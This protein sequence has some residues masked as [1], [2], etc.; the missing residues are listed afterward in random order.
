VY[1]LDPLA[2]S[3]WPDF[4]RRHPDASVFHTR[5]WLEALRRTYGYAAVAYTTSPPATPLTN[6]V[7]FCDVRSWLTGRRL[8]SLP[9][10]DHCEPLLGTAA[11][12]DAILGELRRSV[13]S[14]R[15]RYLE[16]RPTRMDFQATA[17]SSSSSFAF[18]RLD[19]QPSLD[20]LF[21]ALHKD[22]IQ[23]KVRRAEREALV[24]ETGRSASLVQA[25]YDL[26]LITRRRHQLPPQ[27]L[28]WFRTLT[29]CLGGRISI[30]IAAKEGV[31]VAG[32]VVLRHGTTLVYK[33][34]ASDARHHNLGA[35]PFLFWHA[36]REGKTAGFRLL[37]LGRS[38]SDNEGLI[39]FK[40]RL[41][42]ARTR[43]S[44]ARYPASTAPALG[45]SRAMAAARLIF[46]RL[47]DP[48]LATT[49]RLFY[50]HVG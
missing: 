5:E 31:P 38:D 37:D 39:T 43:L 35:M 15:W 46:A 14:R 13:D 30:S 50:R 23:R 22:S 26:Q 3:R 9:F 1:E 17:F 48:L 11:D 25:F 20:E 34:G 6:G 28:A 41:G 44:Y 19:L 21:R 2:D 4:V 42:A 7:V 32:I 27:P 40:D 47:P 12:R 29:D 33:Y 16:I 36:I 49:G 24:Y 10:A 18:H 8:V 45:P